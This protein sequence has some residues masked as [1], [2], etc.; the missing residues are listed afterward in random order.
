[1]PSAIAVLKAREGDCNEHA[2][3][4]AALA[5]AAGIPTKLNI[6]LVYENNRFFYHTW[7]S[8]FL[9]EWIE[10]DPMLGQ[11]AVDATHIILAE[12][13]LKNQRQI[14]AV[15][16]RLKARVITEL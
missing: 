10:M 12:G 3:L 5:R 8:V 4:F 16:G 6:G 7:V 11:T 15:M 1:M 9:G 14:M 13:E 2:Y